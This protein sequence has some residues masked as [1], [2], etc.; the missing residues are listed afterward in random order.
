MSETLY[1]SALLG[2]VGS[3]EQLGAAQTSNVFARKAMPSVFNAPGSYAAGRSLVALERSRVFDALHPGVS[4]DPAALSAGSNF[5]NGPK[6]IASFSGT[7]LP[8]T[9]SL[10]KTLLERS[11]MLP[12]DVIGGRVT[13]PSSVTVVELVDALESE[14][15]PT[16]KVHA[17]VI[18]PVVASA[19][20]AVASAVIGDWE[21]LSMILLGMVCNGLSSSALKQGDLTFTRPVT[22]AGAPAGDGYLDAGTELVVLKGSE[23]AVASVTRGRFTLRYKDERVY[24][25]IATCGT[26]MTA[27]CFI[28]LL[29]VPQGTFYGQILFL[30][31]MVISWLY[32]AHVARQEK[33]AW[34]RLVLEDLLKAP[35]MKR[36]SLGTRAATAVFLM[37]L[38]KPDNI[39]EQLALL[40]PNNTP[41]WRYWR[42]TVARRLQEEKPS[43]AGVPIDATA[44]RPD[45]LTLLNTLLTDAQTAVD[46]YTKL[47][48]AKF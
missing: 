40:L 22:T 43:F 31:S 41:V 24:R 30:F 47:S 23:S 1:T 35:S 19:T 39:E 27:Q 37:Q 26:L 46:G 38:L 33:A 14:V 18:I 20:A 6:Y 3:D 2:F 10:A 36:Y 8:S 13:T 28:Q 45:E 11:R 7:V 29:I 21:I 48:G 25:W 12:L 44:F 4:A 32:N 16:A 15:H 5:A 17:P 42:Q 34:D 9:G